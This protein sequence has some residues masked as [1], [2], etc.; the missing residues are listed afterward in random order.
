MHYSIPYEKDLNQSQLNAV[1]YHHSPLLVLAGAGSGK[2]RVITYKIAYLINECGFDPE[3]I[4]AVTFTNKASNEMKI[5]VMSLL[6]EEVDVWIKTFHS[7]AAK[8]LRVYGSYFGIKQGFSIIDQHDQHTVVRDIIKKMNIDTESHKPE[9]YVYLIERAKDNLLDP[10]EAR[11]AEFSTDPLFYD[12]FHKYASILK[13]D[14]LFDFGDLIYN[15]VRILRENKEA[16]TLLKRR[17]RY[18]LV[19]EFQ[20]TNHSQYILVKLLALPEGE[21]CVVGDD[22][23]SIYGFRGAKVENILNFQADYKGTKVIKL[24]ENYRSFQTILSASSSLINRNTGRLGKTL[25]TRKG[26]GEKL[27]FFHASTDRNEAIFIASEIQEL[28][29]R[30]GYSFSDM[31]IFYRMNAQSRSFESILS[32]LRIPYIIVGG[33]RFYEREEIKDILSYIRLVINPMDEISLRRVMAKPPRGIGTKTVDTLIQCTIRGGVPFYDFKNCSEISSSRSKKLSNFTALIMELSEEMNKTYPPDILR[34]IYD[35]TGYVEWLK[36]Q[37]KEEKLANL[38]ELYNA[39]EE[40]SRR[41]P[42]S[43]ISEF[44]EEVSLNQAAGDEE[45]QNNRVCLI[46]LHNAKGLEFPVVFIAGMEEGIFPHFLSGGHKDDIEEERRLCY[47]GMTRAMEKLYLTA[48]KLRRLY[49]RNIERSISTFIHEL[50]EDLLL[51]KEE[52]HLENKSVSYYSSEARNQIKR[53]G[54]KSY[55]RTDSFV[56]SDI[57]K[58]T[59]IIHKQFGKGKV[60]EL[61]KGIAVIKFDDGKIMKFMLQ[62]TPIRREETDED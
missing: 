35:E 53:G 17:F 42:S 30:N 33:L 58:G 14:N 22:D 3:S 21:V 62:Y 18:I 59:R 48:A 54:D 20:D 43:P 9:K 7:T 44:L 56:E 10:E 31:A 60:L 34:K 12:I 29:F 15:V 38:D 24:E 2:T 37:N 51:Y 49:G 28:I 6:G 5:R 27:C 23:Q 25:Y 4:L 40:F 45:F 55:R 50:P 46:T 13:G 47:V 11:A 36:E 26:K 1:Q 52:K 32:Q 39:V 8:L 61:E 16:L 19:D 57:E 41:N